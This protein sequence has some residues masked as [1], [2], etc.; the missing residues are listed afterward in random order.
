M[1]TGIIKSLGQINF[2]QQREDEDLTLSVLIDNYPPTL[3][4][5]LKIGC[6]IACS[7]VCL[8]L[9]NKDLPC[10]EKIALT[11]QASDETRDKTT[12]KNW[13]VKDFI[14]IELS[15]KVG[16]E[17]GG[18]MVSGHIDEISQ[19][20]DII[21]NKDSHIFIFSLPNKVKKFISE[22]GSIVL[23]G[24]SLTINEVQKEQFSVNIIKHS[25][26]ITNFHLLKIGDYVNLEIDTIA[27]Y[28]EKIV[29]DG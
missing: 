19:I 8:T 11:F 22:K 7:G 14:N 18:H 20:K 27:R 21:K 26:D 25:F 29:N 9:I 13:L 24:V 2:L 16:D 6:S 23:N 15:L 5:S 10:S 4:K 12:I 1:F 3:Y 28:L 17:I